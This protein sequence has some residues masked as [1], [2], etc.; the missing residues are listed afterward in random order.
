MVGEPIDDL[1]AGT[2]SITVAISLLVVAVGAPYRPVDR[3]DRGKDRTG[4][5]ARIAGKPHAWSAPSF[6]SR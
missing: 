2:A 1:E 3:L 6:G 5:R 4:R